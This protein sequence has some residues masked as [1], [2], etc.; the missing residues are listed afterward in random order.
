MSERE[1]WSS[2]AE[3]MV[4]LDTM[5][6]QVLREAYVESTMDLQAYAE[7]VRCL[8]SRKKAIRE[9][10]AAVRTFKEGVIAAA[11]GRGVD[12][13]RGGPEDLAVLA[14]LYKE[15]AHPR[16]VGDIEYELGI[17][18]CVPPAGVDSPA[19]L[20]REVKRWEET[21]ATLGEDAQLANVDLQNALQRQ[22]QT[23]QLMSNVSKMIHETSMAIIRK[24]G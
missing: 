20:D 13:H 3:A 18:D 22:Q 6:Q 8:N 10:L 1:S 2:F 24:I 16:E 15:H 19:Q 21:L 7:K 11:R 17:P 12:L 23:L 14:E 5:V 9:H 4:D